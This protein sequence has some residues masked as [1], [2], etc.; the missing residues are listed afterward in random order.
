MGL[1]DNRDYQCV[2]LAALLHDIG[3]F[4]QRTGEHAG[5]KHAELSAWFV[6][7]R[8]GDRWRAVEGI[9]GNHHLPDA[10][11]APNPRLTL[12]ITLADWLSSGERLDLAG[13]ETERPGE[14]AITSV[15]SLLYNGNGD[16]RLPLIELPGDG[17]LAPGPDVR[18]DGS[19]YRDLWQHFVAEFSRTDVAAFGLL[20]DQMLALLE[21]YSMFVPAAAWKSKPDISLYHH[22]KSTAAIAACLYQDGF[23]TAALNDLMKV[24]RGESGDNRRVAY[25]VGGDISGI[26]DFL[27]T[28]T[29]QGALKGLRGRSLYL[30]LLPEAAAARFLDRFELARANLLYC[31]GGHFYLLVP[32]VA[33]AQTRIA[34]I[35][36]HIDRTLSK[37]HRGRLSLALASQ[38]LTV[39]DFS[40]KG[41]GMAW[42]KL[43]AGLARNKR[44]RS[45]TRLSDPAGLLETLG[46]FGVGG[47]E[48]ACQVCGE[49]LE[50][51]SRDSRKCEL[52]RSFEEL[53]RN[54]SNARFLRE[55]PVEQPA[56][57]L[58]G[59]QQV[60]AALG[61]QY[62]FLEATLQPA[63]EC[64]L[65]ATAFL[66]DRQSNRGFRFL[67]RH[68]PRGQDG[69]ATL[70]E[71]A[72][73][74]NG[75]PRWGVLRMDVDNLGETFKS[76]LGED[77]SISRLTML[78]YLLSYFFTARVEALAQEFGNTL[79]LVYSGGDDLF[80][81]GA[82][83]VLPGVAQRIRDE[84][85]RFTS[86]RLTA[87]AGIAIAPGDKYP[88]YEAADLA[89]SAVVSAKSAGRNRMCVFEHCVT[90][91]ELADAQALLRRLTELLDR[92]LPR[93]LLTLLKKSW[94][95]R[96]D[97]E[98][99]AI[100]MFPLWRLFYAFKRLKE[101]HKDQMS[102]IDDLEKAVVKEN[103]L[104]PHLDMI[105]RW[106]ELA[107]RR[108]DV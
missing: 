84:F 14:V 47:E 60:L 85:S 75:V 82:W 22:L 31:G 54:I 69:V 56:P 83:S 18:V 63:Q 61:R 108:S 98:A 65:N 20:T 7:E 33:D 94:L 41:F 4:W 101:R 51:D 37:A 8:L 1:N 16:E 67:A 100:K 13:G 95:D 80:A 25:L 104:H 46:P 87:S 105:V 76:G 19:R 64:L 58:V 9:V 5:R 70:E 93:S 102:A 106:A 29:A 24:F 71:L 92:G 78:S 44:R 90:W 43:H 50:P 26:Q 36:A 39:T 86:G 68:A 34:D 77:R 73:R 10:A 3:K 57:G 91:P 35:E 2:V 48:C 32:A 17:G 53:G 6:R 81:I 27:Y 49:E 15:F 79:Y 96:L 11:S 62:A 42:D 40:R 89:G 103:D 23:D 97:A 59:Y 52:C 55:T 66:N 99:G 74:S 45:H 107:T 21:K 88:V 28:L 12:T 72:A 30:Q 38:P